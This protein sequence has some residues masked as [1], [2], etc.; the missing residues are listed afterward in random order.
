LNKKHF[1]FIDNNLRPLRFSAISASLL[2]MQRAR[3]SAENAK[4]QNCIKELSEEK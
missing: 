1:I 3:S 4:K 2:A